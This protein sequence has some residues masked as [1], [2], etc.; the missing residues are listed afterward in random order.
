MARLEFKVPEGGNN[1]L[2]IRY[3]GEGDTAYG[4]MTELQVL[5]DNYE[6]VRG[7]IDPR[8]AHGSAYG[9]VAAAR[10]YQRPIGQW[11]FQEVTVK[12]TTLK[13]ELNGTVIL[14]TDLSKVD[15]TTFMGGNPHPG[16]DRTNGF[17]GFAG[18]SDPVAFRAIRIKKLE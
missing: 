15:P 5:D 16:K 1:G 7:A 9:M 14:D 3:P 13:V 12:G 18:H 11:N 2:A 8:Q 10:G 4:G 6:K 17:F